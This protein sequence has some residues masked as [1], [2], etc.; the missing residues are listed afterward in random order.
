MTEYGEEALQVAWKGRWDTGGYNGAHDGGQN[1][2]PEEHALDGHYGSI[3]ALILK[4]DYIAL[5]WASSLPH[6]FGPFGHTFISFLSIVLISSSLQG[7]CATRYY[8]GLH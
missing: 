2:A 4:I 7:D 5:L 1:L 8:E 6:L 3:L